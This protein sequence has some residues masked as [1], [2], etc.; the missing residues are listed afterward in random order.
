LEYLP[1][2]AARRDVGQLGGEFLPVAFHLLPSAAKCG[3]SLSCLCQCCLLVTGLIISRFLKR[4][5]AQTEKRKEFV[6]S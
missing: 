1:T 3:G 2:L 4:P 5:W 6:I